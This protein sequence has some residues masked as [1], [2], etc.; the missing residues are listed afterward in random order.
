MRYSRNLINYLQAGGPMPE[1]PAMMEGGPEGGAPMGPEGAPAGPEAGP[2][3]EAQLQ[4]MAGQLAQMVVQQV[5][6]PQMASQLLHMA[7]DMAA[8]A[9]GGAPMGPEG[10]PVYARRGTKLV[11]IR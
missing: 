10:E 6:D 8:Q 3:P 4:E 5:G 7:G 9:G 1:D 2:G 11:R